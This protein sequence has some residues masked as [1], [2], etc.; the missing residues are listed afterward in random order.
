[1]AHA[2]YRES[3]PFPFMISHWIHLL[4]M[5][6]LVFTGFYIHAP[7]GDFSMATMRSLHFAA[8]WLVLVNL[9]IR[10]VLAFT[11]RT[12]SLKGTRDVVPD[13]RNFSPQSENRGQ[14]IE[15]IKYYLFI[16]KT[17]PATGKYNPMQKLAYLAMAALL[18][19]QGYSGFAIYGPMDQ[20][21]VLAA[22]TALVGGLQNMRTI[23]YLIM[24]VFILITMIHV[25]LSVA[26]D[27]DA[28]PLMFYGKETQAREH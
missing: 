9:V 23:H 15:T 5:V 27:I 17:H 22:G 10:V 19:A 4:C 18:V 12:S 26:E 7:F 21:P 13:Y 2:T 1:M 24:W 16:R 28:L 6:V 20:V 11:W 14:F 8:M 3:H 25:Y